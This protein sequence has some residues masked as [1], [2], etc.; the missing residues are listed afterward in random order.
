MK[1]DLAR[2]NG[3]LVST[4]RLNYLT[5][6]SAHKRSIKNAVW[7]LRLDS[8]SSTEYASKNAVNPRDSDDARVTIN[9]FGN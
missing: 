1:K 6:I 3:R 9:G 4:P 7:L 5:A 8:K 2:L